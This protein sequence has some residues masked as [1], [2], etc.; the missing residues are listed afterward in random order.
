MPQ[1]GATP[2]TAATLVSTGGST[3]PTK[4][5]PMLRDTSSLLRDTNFVFRD[6]NFMLCG[7]DSVLSKKG[8]GLKNIPF[9]RIGQTDSESGFFKNPNF[10]AISCHG[11]P[12]TISKVMKFHPKDD[13]MFLSTF[14]PLFWC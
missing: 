9:C 5:E 11:C 3:L 4:S 13:P 10:F 2:T 7:T 6:A 14:L 8:F 1:K 12:K